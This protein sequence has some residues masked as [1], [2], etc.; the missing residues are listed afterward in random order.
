MKTDIYLYFLGNCKEA[1]AFYKSI[2]GG[3][4][5]IM[6]N[7]EAP[8]QEEMGGHRPGDILHARLAAGDVTLLG[9]DCPPEYFNP[10]KGFSISL[11]VESKEEAERTF[12]A[13]SEDGQ[14]FC[15]LGETFFALNFGMLTDKFGI[16]WMVIYPK[17]MSSPN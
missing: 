7:A 12:N 13:L 17:P 9:S 10:P 11:T 1:F 4:L 2:L 15:P 14:I 16:A 8:V 6:T 5:F 3:D